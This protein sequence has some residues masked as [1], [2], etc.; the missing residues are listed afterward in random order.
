MRGEPIVCSVVDALRCFTRSKIDLLVVG[1][2]VLSRSDIPSLWNL[3][4]AVTAKPEEGAG[5]SIG[6]LVYTLL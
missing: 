3:Q 4:A 5:E 6:H 1:D 2:F